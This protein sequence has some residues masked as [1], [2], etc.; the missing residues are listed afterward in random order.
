M[1]I[2]LRPV[3]GGNWWESTFFLCASAKTALF[4]SA[5]ST[6]SML[7]FVANVKYDDTS[8]PTWMSDSTGKDGSD[9]GVQNVDTE[10][11]EWTQGSASFVLRG[12]S[13]GRWLKL[14][15]VERRPQE[16]ARLVLWGLS[17]GRWLE[18]EVVELD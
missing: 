12:S 5:V 13:E 10:P 1:T 6:P 2:I 4:I 7:A 11:R 15:V 18:L 17:K 14:E 9:P 3:F 16:P 8:L